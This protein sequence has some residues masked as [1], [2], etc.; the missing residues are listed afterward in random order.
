ML[1]VLRH[2]SFGGHIQVHTKHKQFLDLSGSARAYRETL[3]CTYLP[4]MCSGRFGTSPAKPTNFFILHLTATYFLFIFK[5]KLCPTVE[6][7]PVSWNVNKHLK[8]YI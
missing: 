6:V 5:K 2:T 3:L 1:G 7:T 8:K 4:I